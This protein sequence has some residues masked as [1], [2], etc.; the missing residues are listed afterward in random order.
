MSPPLLFPRE[1]ATGLLVE[2][3]KVII[4]ECHSHMIANR[5]TLLRRQQNADLHACIFEIDEG[6]IAEELDE[7]DIAADD[8]NGLGRTR[9]AK[10]SGPD[11]G[12]DRLRAVK[13]ETLTIDGGRW[14]FVAGPVRVAF[15]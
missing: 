1:R 15:K 11:A 2:D 9:G 5:G 10:V 12:D 6:V 8:I 13:V 3:V 7:I 4:R 14:G